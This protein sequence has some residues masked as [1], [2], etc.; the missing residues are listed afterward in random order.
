MTLADCE[1]IRQDPK[2]ARSLEALT[3]FFTWRCGDNDVAVG[4]NEYAGEIADVEEG[5][6]PKD[7]NWI[8][9]YRSGMIDMYHD[10]LLDDFRKKKNNV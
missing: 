8:E 1:A 5:I 10:G 4:L 7:D 6:P 9:N 2:L 3:S